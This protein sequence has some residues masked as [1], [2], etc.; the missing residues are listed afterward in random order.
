[1]FLGSTKYT[2]FLLLN[3]IALRFFCLS[4]SRRKSDIWVS[5]RFGNV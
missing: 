3:A 2:A 1:M 5:F 4:V